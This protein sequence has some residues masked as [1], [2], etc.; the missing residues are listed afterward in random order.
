M[1]PTT[2]I[3]KIDGEIIKTDCIG[4]IRVSC[5]HR[6]KLLDT[7]ESS[8]MSGQKF[9]EHCGVKYTTFA[10]WIQK[11]RRERNEYPT[12]HAAPP[13]SL[14][15]SLAEVSLAEVELVPIKATNEGLSIELPGGARMILDHPAQAPLAAALI[16]NLSSEN[17]A[18][19]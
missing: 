17:N 2:E 14:L 7:F 4:R 15:Q 11:R 3:C 5:E 13:E 19:L 10:S 1:T 12:K 18:Q 16:Y 6:E 9:A 8:G